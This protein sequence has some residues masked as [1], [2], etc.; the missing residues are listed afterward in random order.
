ML[1]RSGYEKHT[2]IYPTYP[3]FILNFPRDDFAYKFSY[4][5]CI[6]ACIKINAVVNDPNY[7][8]AACNHGLHLFTAGYVTL[9]FKN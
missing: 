3:E 9:S 1:M 7:I 8:T 4:R 6:F 5:I 2:Y